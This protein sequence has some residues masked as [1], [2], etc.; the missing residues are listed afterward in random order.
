[1]SAISAPPS[2]PTARTQANGRRRP[3]LPIAWTP[4]DGLDRPAWISQG[5]HLGALSRKSNWWVGDWLRFG[6]TKWG[7]KYALAAK[8]T[9]HDTHSLENMVYV[10]SHVHISLRRENLSWS[11]HFLVAALEPKEQAYWLDRATECKFSVNDLRI[12]LR[13]AQRRLKAGSD[14][15]DETSGTSD[16]VVCPQCGFRIAAHESSEADMQV[17]TET[18]H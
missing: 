17:A 11:H 6:A 9:G 15:P 2:K 1:M 8:I 5:R 4:P 10:A 14:G 13:A 12:E 7:E 18:E 3:S 16:V